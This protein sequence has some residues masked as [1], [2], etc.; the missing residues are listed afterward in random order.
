M[1]A[2]ALRQAIVQQA[3]AAEHTGGAP[4]QA[5]G[6]VHALCERLEALHDITL[7]EHAQQEFHILLQELRLAEINEQ[8]EVLLA[9]EGLSEEAATQRRQLLAERA[10]LKTSLPELRR[11]AAQVVKD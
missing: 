4:A 5:D 8:L 2:A 7:G 11:A 1:A 9:T 6:G 10:A 3:E